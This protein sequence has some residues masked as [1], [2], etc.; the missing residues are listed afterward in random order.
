MLGLRERRA[1]SWGVVCLQPCWL[2]GDLIVGMRLGGSVQVPG[3]F[4]HTLPHP[5]FMSVWLC[6]RHG[7]RTGP[8]EKEASLAVKTQGKPLLPGRS[9][10]SA[11][12]AESRA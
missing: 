2:V 12:Q 1:E 3:A 9:A 8:G 10:S 6:G 11:G 4:E 7:V 5:P